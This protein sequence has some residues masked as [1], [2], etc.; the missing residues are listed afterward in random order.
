L[1]LD[2]NIF[3]NLQEFIQNPTTL[4]IYLNP[5]IPIALNNIWYASPQQVGFG[6]SYDDSS[7]SPKS[8]NH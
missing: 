2:D 7:H 8:E 1:N 5:K 3:L 6:L 4:K